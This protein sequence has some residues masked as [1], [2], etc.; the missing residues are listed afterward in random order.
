MRNSTRRAWC[1]HSCRRRSGTPMLRCSGRRSPVLAGWYRRTDTD[2]RSCSSPC[3]RRASSIAA[4]PWRDP[5]PSRGRLL[6]FVQDALVQVVDDHAG[7]PLIVDK[8]ALADRIG[9]LLSNFQRLLKDLLGGQAAIDKALDIADPI[10]DNLPLL[11]QISLGEGVA[12]AGDDGLDIERFDALQR[13]EPLPGIAFLQ[14]R[15]ALVEDVVAGEDDPFLRHVD[16]SLRCGVAG[17]MDDVESVVAHVEG[18]LLVKGQFWRVRCRVVGMTDE[19]DAVGIGLLEPLAFFF[20]GAER[21]EV[22][23]EAFL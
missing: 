6:L 8:E 11:L 13:R 12:V 23:L 20:E 9:I 5:R 14:P 15:P 2:S 1:R 19:P 10:L 18:E 4:V 17:H 16:R 21:I 3:T 22:A 7:Q